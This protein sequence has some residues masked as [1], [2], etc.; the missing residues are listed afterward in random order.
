MYLKKIMECPR[1]KDVR[2]LSY[3]DCKRRN[4]RNT[5]IVKESTETLERIMIIQL[6]GCIKIWNYKPKARNM[7]NKKK[8]ICIKKKSKYECS[9]NEIN[10]L[11]WF[12]NKVLKNLKCEPSRIPSKWKKCNGLQVNYCFTI[13]M[14]V[15]S[16]FV[17]ILNST[18]SD[19]LVSR[20]WYQ[21]L[22]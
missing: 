13:I 14:L 3:G 16:Y 22:I 7:K 15:Y 12:R 20:T 17:W 8:K 19:I 21:T 2:E 18:P 11:K 4:T 9:L 6:T 1:G 10:N 5:L